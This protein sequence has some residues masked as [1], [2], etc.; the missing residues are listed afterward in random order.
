MDS[1]TR[2]NTP[3]INSTATLDSASAIT[4]TSLLDSTS[5]TDS[6]IPAQ[7]AVKPKVK[8]KPDSGKKWLLI[9]LFGLIFYLRFTHHRIF[10]L[11]R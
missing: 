10:L 7:S 2:D 9:I 11:P 6:T 8:P 4:T 1:T 3:D 5:T